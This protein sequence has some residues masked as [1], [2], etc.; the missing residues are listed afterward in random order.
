MKT[1]TRNLFIAWAVAFCHVAL[2]QTPVTPV[3]G[4]G[5]YIAGDGFSLEQAIDDG[6]REKSGDAGFAVLVLGAEVSKLTIHGATSEV[7]DVI[8]RGVKGGA[9]LNVCERDVKRMSISAQYF[10]PMVRVSRGF[11]ASESGALD[12]A[13]SGASGLLRRLRALCSQ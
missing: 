11:S 2:A 10:L 6:L 4:Y 12:T 1:G 8:L 7:S 5:L 3:A 9:F 13:E